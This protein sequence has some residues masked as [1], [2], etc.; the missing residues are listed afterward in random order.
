MANDPAAIMTGVAN[1][2]KKVTG[3]DAN[4]VSISDVRQLRTGKTQYVF[5]RRGGPLTRQP[6]TM[7]NTPE[8]LNTWVINVELWIPWRGEADDQLTTV[9]AE[10]QKLLSE[11]D[12]WPRLVATAGVLDAFATQVAEPEEWHM[13]GPWWRQLILVQVQEVSTPTRSE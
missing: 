1:V 6:L 11:F 10:V 12:K 2:V 7:G 4:N 13:G 3:Y 8:V 5:I 9:D